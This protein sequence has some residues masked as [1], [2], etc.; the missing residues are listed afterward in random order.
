[1]LQLENLSSKLSSHFKRISNVYKMH[2][3]KAVLGIYLSKFPIL[4]R[5]YQSRFGPIF[6]KTKILGSTMFL[7]VHDKGLHRL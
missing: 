1:M 7:S 4:E 5:F 6:V 3:L 2:G